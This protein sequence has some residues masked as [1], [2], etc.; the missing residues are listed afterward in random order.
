MRDNHKW[1]HAVYQALDDF[2]DDSDK[3]SYSIEEFDVMI[4]L[5]EGG[6]FLGL[7]VGSC[8][9]TSDNRMFT[10]VGF[11]KEWFD[12]RPLDQQANYNDN[13]NIHDIWY[14][15]KHKDD[16][17][18]A[19]SYDIKYPDKRSLFLIKPDDVKLMPDFSDNTS[20]YL[21]NQT[22]LQ[23]FIT[24]MKINELPD[25]TDATSLTKRCVGMKILV[26]LIDKNGDDV[27]SLIEP[28]FK[29]NLISMLLRE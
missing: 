19:L 9:I 8:G 28:E 14:E 26:N 13:F 29:N 16:A 23:N 10:I 21:L 18:L 4:S 3:N 7:N 6:E 22:R 25:K 2:L 17:I 1:A 27:N 5:L 24:K 11:C 15:Y 12:L 20:S